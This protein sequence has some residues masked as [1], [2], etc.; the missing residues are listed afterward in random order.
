[1]L[2]DNTLQKYFNKQADGFFERCE[3]KI[4]ISG[5][6][7]FEIK[8]NYDYFILFQFKS[9]FFKIFIFSKMKNT[10]SIGYWLLALFI[11]V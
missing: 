6:W 3:C 2:K 10:L 1:V 11:F 8:K 5:W 9:N 7:L 4:F